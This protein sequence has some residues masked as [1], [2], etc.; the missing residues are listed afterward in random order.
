MKRIKNK[1]TELKSKNQSAF[2]AYICGGDPNY[3]LSLEVLKK[4]PENGVD[5]IELGVPFLDPSGD[6]PI[7]EEAAKRAIKN[8]MNLKKTL[9]MTE[10]FRK[11]NNSTPIILMGYY[12]NFLKYGLEKVFFDI[13][14]SGADGVLIVDLPL[15]ERDE[16]FESISR[17]NIDFINL[18]SPLSN[19]SRI[20]EISKRE[21][22]SGFLYLISMLGITGTKDAKPEENIENL[23]K[24]RNISDLE[25]VI[26]FGIKTPQQAKK[27]V[28]LG[29]DGVV[30]GST[31]VNEIATKFLDGKGEKEIIDGVVKIVKE[32]SGEIKK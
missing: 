18:I 12:N 20:E 31:L 10:E 30:I 16:V 29:F 3:E 27:F 4:L 22:A 13:E 24:I 1:F 25:T 28:D 5:I 23:N 11:N 32:F 21:R 7:I 9:Q 19:E 2:I 14:K 26:G 6:G 8:G 15:E 17:T